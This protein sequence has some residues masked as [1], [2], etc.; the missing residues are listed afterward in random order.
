MALLTIFST[1]GY[2]TQNIKQTIY[3][4]FITPTIYF[5]SACCMPNA[6]GTVF[7][8]RSPNIFFFECPIIDTSPKLT[9]LQ[10]LHQALSLLEDR[11]L[12]LIDS[13]DAGPTTYTVSSATT[14]RKEKQL[15]RSR[16]K[17]HIRKVTPFCF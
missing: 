12:S 14:A 2:S 13:V 4:R 7:K 10:T 3:Q 9:R 17:W 1:K 16:M 6:S 8:R 11:R 5:S 15:F